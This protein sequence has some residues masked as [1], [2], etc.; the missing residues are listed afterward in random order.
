MTSEEIDL[1]MDRGFSIERPDIVLRQNSEAS[2]V[3]Y[4]GPGSIY[5]TPDGELAFKCYAR[6]KGDFRALGRLLGSN[7]PKE[8]QIIPRDQ[9]FSLKA[10]SLRGEEWLRE[11]ILPEVSQGVDG[12]QIVTGHLYELVKRVEETTDSDETAY[13]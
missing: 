10:L 3:V 5:Q 1:Y 13:V 11:Y 4:E 6:G 7:A 12:D 9:Y 8:G 2:P